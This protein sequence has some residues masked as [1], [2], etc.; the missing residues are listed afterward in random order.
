MI[1][2]TGKK[3]LLISSAILIVFGLCLCAQCSAAN[4]KKSRLNLN[5]W[6]NARMQEKNRLVQHVGKIQKLLNLNSPGQ[7][8]YDVVAHEESDAGESR[9]LMMGSEHNVAQQDL[10]DVNRQSE[11]YGSHNFTRIESP[12]LAMKIHSDSSQNGTSAAKS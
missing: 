7:S 6:T 12:D 10:R 8:L 11:L 2:E 9:F 4:A 1:N 5:Q 3:A